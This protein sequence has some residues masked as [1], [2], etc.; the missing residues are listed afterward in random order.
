MISTD[1]WRIGIVRAPIEQ[2]IARE[3]ID[4]LETTWVTADESLCYVADPF[5]VWRDDELCVFME[6]YDYRT[7]RGRIDAARYDSTLTL[8]DRRTVLREPWHLSYPIVFEAGGEFWMLP[9]AAKSGRSTL[10]RAVEFPWRWA[11]EPR[12]A[13]P[14]A[15]I[16]PTPVHTRDGWWLL[17]TPPGRTKEMRRSVL[18]LARAPNPFAPWQGVEA[19]PIHLGPD[20]GRMGGTPVRSG[21]GWLL[22]T[23]DA[24][25]GYGTGV[26]IQRLS[27]PA[28]ATAL[29]PT[30][31]TIR[32]PASQRP[33]D[34]GLHTLSAAGP[35]TLVDTKKASR[36]FHRLGV[37]IGRR[38]GLYRNRA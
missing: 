35:F 32:A 13:F 22:P 27:D 37:E 28:H 2:V 9:E 10:Y 15:A 30:G 1:I 3:S 17:F 7:H 18:K 23:Q 21:D 11:P 8:K 26:L 31:V 12:F 16:D 38:F 5:G 24:R 36:S 20:G 4:G 14:A 33:W 25:G 34:R 6:Y 29:T 19:P